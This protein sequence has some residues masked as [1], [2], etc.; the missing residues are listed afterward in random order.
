M[1]GPEVPGGAWTTETALAYMQVQYDLHERMSQARHDALV[2]LL[3]ERSAAQKA[4]IEAALASA[5][6]AVAKS[7]ESNET[8]FR[9]ADEFR[10]R[11]SSQAATLLPRAEYET[12]HNSLVQQI[13]DLGSRMDR[14]QGADTGR[15]ANRTALY[16]AIGATGGII[17]IILGFVALIAVFKQ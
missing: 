10:G 9:S 16:A 11:L 13:R 3:D 4:A 17:G 6:E 7:E 12:A 8:R 14:D 15:N 2:G 1:S 5:K